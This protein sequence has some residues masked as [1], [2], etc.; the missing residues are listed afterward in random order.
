MKFSRSLIIKVVLFAIVSVIIVGLLPT[1]LQVYLEGKAAEKGIETFNYYAEISDS[2]FYGYFGENI[3]KNIEG[4]DFV[5]LQELG[6]EINVDFDDTIELIKKPFGSVWITDALGLTVISLV[7]QIAETIVNAKISNMFYSTI[8][9]CIG[10]IILFV[11]FF[12]FFSKNFI[13]SKKEIFLNE[14]I[15]PQWFSVILSGLNIILLASLL[16]IITYVI[17]VSIPMSIKFIS[18]PPIADFGQINYGATFYITTFVF[19]FGIVFSIFLLI[20]YFKMKQTE[21]RKLYTF[22]LIIPILALGYNLWSST[23][24]VDSVNKIIVSQNISSN[25]QMVIS[26]C[27]KI[28]YSA[29]QW[30][31]TNSHENGMKLEELT[32]PDVAVSPENENGKYIFFVEGNLLTITGEGKLVNKDGT[33]ALGVTTYNAET[34]SIKTEIIR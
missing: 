1:R 17:V 22:I 6:T 13:K 33:T 5:K 14:S 19:L 26:D 2:V 16:G 20:F 24:H 27:G 7:K 29:R 8:L 25:R 32:F 31:L 18:A 4:F 12:V 10:I 34:D 9:S 11:L 23:R 30:Y 15:K 21:L 28:A 3:P